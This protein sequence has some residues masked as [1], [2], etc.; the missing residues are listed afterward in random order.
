MVFKTD[1]KV[2]TTPIA[3]FALIFIAA[4]CMACFSCTNDTNEASNDINKENANASYLT[5]CMET[6]LP[7]VRID[8]ENGAGIFDKVTEVPMNMK[9]LNEDS[10]ESNYKGT[11]RIRGN[12]TAGYPKKPYKIKLSEK[13]E[14]LGMPKNK[15]W[16]LLANYCDKTLMRTAIGFKTSELLN[17]SW[18]PKAEFVELII[19]DE[20][21]GNYLLTESVK[22]GKN[23]VDINDDVKKGD[24]GY[25]IEKDGYY[26]SE[27]V[28]FVTSDYKYG[29]S[30]KFPDNED[31][32]TEIKEY[33]E[34]YINDFERVLKSE[35]TLAF[36]EEN[37]YQKYID[38]DSWCRWFLVQNIIANLDSNYFMY[39]KDTTSSKLYMGP[40]WD[41]EWSIGIGW[42]DGARPNPNHGWINPIYFERL[43]DDSHFSAKVKEIWRSELSGLETEL[44]GYIEE[45]REKLSK[46]QKVNFTRWNIMNS[47]VSVGG[48]PMGSYD[49]EV[50]CDKAFLSE[51]IKWLDSAINGL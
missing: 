2:K 46:S 37:G 17:L 21:L 42:Y 20:Y 6:G 24:Y 31:I 7:V 49:A 45:L 38:L 15:S 26:A 51:H 5:Q 30:F 9:I 11:I 13:A 41:F 44:L 33:I 4:A 25:L 32:T 27:P 18:T 19:N 47:V 22:E 35:N 28:W 3:I 39:K 14:I 12:A 23:R 1:F 10:S 48:I 34:N 36:D 43:L 8:T 50:D 29:Y 40:V 16:V